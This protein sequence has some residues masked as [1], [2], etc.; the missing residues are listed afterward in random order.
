MDGYTRYRYKGVNR[1]EQTVHGTLVARNKTLANIELFKHHI[2]VTTL[3]HERPQ[4]TRITFH[5]ITHFTKSLAG[6]LSAHIPLREALDLL[7]QGEDNPLMQTLLARIKQNVESGMPLAHALKHHPRYFTDVYCHIAH[8][9]ERSGSLSILLNQLALH[10]EREGEMRKKLRRA[11][12][13]PLA[14]VS[15]ALVVTLGL[16][17]FVVPQFQALFASFNATLPKATRMLIWLSDALR[18]HGFLLIFCVFMLF[19]MF[20]AL[21]RHIHR[22]RPIADGVKLKLPLLKNIT[23][24]TIL[25]RITHTMSILLNAGL[26]MVEAIGVCANVAANKRYTESLLRIQSQLTQGHSL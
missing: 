9:G 6:L 24:L 12:T 19:I 21:N 2:K 15:I 13:Y 8:T 11:L 5:T 4:N 18:I 20:K 23:E 10:R 22:I 25:T 1:A 7:Q 17:L 14:I 3:T 26:P 16:L